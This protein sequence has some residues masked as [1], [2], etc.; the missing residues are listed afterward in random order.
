MRLSCQVKVKQDMKIEIPPEVFSARRWECTVRSNRNVATFIKELVMELPPGEALEFRAGGYIQ[1]ECPPH[2]VHF[3]DFQI[4]DRYR[5]DWDRLNLWTPDSQCEEPV[6][7]AYSMAN[8]PEANRTVML[9]VRIALPPPRKRTP[10]PR[11]H[12][13]YTILP[14]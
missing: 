5:P 3:K 6:Q 10:P 14:I 1:I 13:Y 4:D 11:T 8:Y 12:H 9:N 7:R 2:E